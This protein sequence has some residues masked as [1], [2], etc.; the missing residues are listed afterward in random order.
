MTGVLGRANPLVLVALGLGGLVGSLAVRDVT[1]GVV[2]L[3]AYLAAG[4]LLLP[5]GA[6]PAARYLTVVVG[7]LSVAW[8]AW[9]LGGHD[10]AVALVAGLRVAVLALPG[11]A[12]APLVDPSALADQLGQRLRLPARFVVGVAAALHRFESLGQVWEQADRARR[13]RG[14]GPGPG[15]L[16]RGRHAASVTFAVLVATLRDATSMAVAMDARGF[17]RAHAR[18]WAEPAPWT[19][20]DGGVLALGVVGTVL[21]YALAVLV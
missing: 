8:S 9:L 16:E 13:S 10:L 15:P 14:F 1:T 18:T 3:G 12:V 6:G 2:T 20:L 21:P 7:G 5:R 11:V 19:R 17:A 4:T